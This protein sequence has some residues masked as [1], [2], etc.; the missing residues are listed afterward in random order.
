MSFPKSY[1]VHIQMSFS[2]SLRTNLSFE[3][4]LIH[5]VSQ[6]EEVYNHK[7]VARSKESL[8]CSW[9]AIHENLLDEFP[10]IQLSQKDLETKWMNL[11]DTWLK[12]HKK[13]VAGKSVKPYVYYHIMDFLKP[14][15]GFE[16]S[17]ADGKTEVPETPQPQP[18]TI[19]RCCGQLAEELFNMRENIRLEGGT[20]LWYWFVKFNNFQMSSICDQYAQICTICLRKLVEAYKFQQQCWMAEQIFKAEQVVE[21]PVVVEQGPMETTELETKP[22]Q[23]QQD[24]DV[25]SKNVTHCC[26]ICGKVILDKQKAAHYRGHNLE[27]NICSRKFKRVKDLVLHTRT[28]HKI[29]NAKVA[30][31]HFS[32]LTKCKICNL[33]YNVGS[34]E[35]HVKR[36]HSTDESKKNFLC[37]LCGQTFFEKVQLESHIKKHSSNRKYIVEWP[38]IFFYF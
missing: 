4:S 32:L 24:P 31:K 19:C 23:S 2:A 14:V 33:F 13:M 3:E 11:K 9:A 21:K 26:K 10:N 5:H 15:Y 29:D 7:S 8:L 12:C 27:C 28:V 37:A 1:S 6:Y 22:T 25:D 18:Q 16:Q 34:L 20:D 30:R 17:T 36:K 38:I 35:A